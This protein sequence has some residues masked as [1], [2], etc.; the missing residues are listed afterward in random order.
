MTELAAE[1]NGTARPVMLFEGHDPHRRSAA[2]FER[3]MQEIRNR[4]DRLLVSIEDYQNEIENRRREDEKKA[5]HMHDGR[6]VYVDGQHFRDEYGNTLHGSDLTEAQA[7]YRDHPDASTWASH[8]QI[9]QQ[10][11]EA[12]SLKQKVLDERAGTSD[13]EHAND[14]LT[15]YEHEL[16]QQM[17]HRHAEMAAHPVDYGDASL[18]DL[19]ATSTVA[20]NAA[21]AGET[22]TPA[23]VISDTESE[24][25]GN[26]QTPRPPAPGAFKL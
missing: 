13:P 18:A 2:K 20:F 19:P 4:S 7:L 9:R 3:M 26:K 8:E 22:E 5:L 10:A 14:R 11:E 25:A 12:E 23:T 1:R 17:E 6:H 24:T 21:A 16:H 15:D